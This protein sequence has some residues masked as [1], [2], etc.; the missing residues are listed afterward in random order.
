MGCGH[1]AQGSLA[2]GCE[3]SSCIV[4]VSPL[5]SAAWTSQVLLPGSTGSTVAML[6]K[7]SSL[8]PANSN[9]YKSTS[10]LEFLPWPR[11]TGPVCARRCLSPYLL[12]QIHVHNFHACFHG[13]V[14][15]AVRSY[16]E[17]HVNAALTPSSSAPR[18]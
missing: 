13:L 2:K 16:K 5:Q 7:Q 12:F 17:L 1:Q 4:S 6:L 9:M 11:C 14:A 8:T 3:A 15:A 10:T 18:M